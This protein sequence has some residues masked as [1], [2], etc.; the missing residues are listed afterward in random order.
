MFRALD[1]LRPDIFTTYDWAM[2]DNLQRYSLVIMY[3]F[4]VL[5]VDSMNFF[6]KFVLWVPAESDILKCRVALWG[7]TAIAAS[8]EFFEFIDDP[9][10]KRVGPFMWLTIYTVLIEL[11]IWS[12]FSRGMFDKPFPTGVIILDTVYF[13]LIFLGGVYATYNG[14]TKKIESEK[15][16]YNLMDPPVTIESTQRILKEQ[17]KK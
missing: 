17:K 8:K 1:K 5:L 4:I 3:I 9:N 16:E 7:F 12:K 6:M 2:F 10:C 11:C 13:S 14:M 15:A